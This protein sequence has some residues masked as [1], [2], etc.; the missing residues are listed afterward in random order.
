MGMCCLRR[1]RI[2][3]RLKEADRGHTVITCK[4]LE[5]RR[6]SS[7]SS[8]A[9]GGGREWQPPGSPPGAQPP[10]SPPESK[11][12]ESPPE[13]QS[14]ASPP[15]RKSRKSPFERRSWD[16]PAQLPADRHPVASSRADSFTQP[17]VAAEDTGP[18]VDVNAG[19]SKV[20]CLEDPETGLGRMSAGEAVRLWERSD[21]PHCSDSSDEVS[22]EMCVSRCTYYNEIV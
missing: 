19:R 8:Q 4:P 3:D 2:V 6:V 22:D 15:E 9:A 1:H 10:A 16:S 13:R 11:S 18:E 7:V 12:R 21:G 14:S 5:R 17:S 20:D